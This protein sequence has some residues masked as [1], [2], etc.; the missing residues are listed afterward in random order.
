MTD[1]ELTVRLVDPA[2]EPMRI[3]S[4]LLDIRFYVGGRFR[5]AFA[6]GQTDGEGVCRTSLAA[7]E[8]QLEAN[9]RLFLMDYNTP[10]EDCD[11]IVGIVAP[12]AGEL[13][14]RRAA[15]AKWW[16]EDLQLSDGEANQLVHC[17]EQKFE[18]V[19]AG[20]RAIALVCEG[21]SVS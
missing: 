3:A 4:V 15:R 6:L 16:P 18:L 11:A 20:D 21:R 19:G 14:E 13:A 8:R 5:Y 1:D 10:L 9:R 17:R 2:G 7:I 12:S